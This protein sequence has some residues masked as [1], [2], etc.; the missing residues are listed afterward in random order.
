MAE[1]EAE[2]PPA[3]DSSVLKQCSEC[4]INIK[5]SDDDSKTDIHGFCREAKFNSKN[6]CF[7]NH[8]ELENG[9]IPQCTTCAFRMSTYKDRLA[10]ATKERSMQVAL[11]RAQ[12]ST[13]VTDTRLLF[14]ILRLHQKPEDAEMTAPFRSY[15]ATDEGIQTLASPEGQRQL[16]LLKGRLD[17][18][19]LSSI[20]ELANLTPLIESPEVREIDL[21][22]CKSLKV[23]PVESVIEL[24]SLKKLVLQ[25]CPELLFPPKEIAARDGAAVMQFL[26]HKIMDLKGTSLIGKEL[27]LFGAMA[28][29]RIVEMDVSDC[30]KLRSLPLDDILNISTLKQLRC[31]NCP[32]LDWP[33]QCV[34]PIGGEHTLECARSG[35]VDLR[36]RAAEL[37]AFPDPSTLNHERCTRIILTGCGRVKVIP[38]EPLLKIPNLSHLELVDTGVLWPPTKVIARGGEAVMEFLHSGEC[39]LEG[40][41]GLY[42]PDLTFL[43]EAFIRHLDLSRIVTCP[44]PPRDSL[45]PVATS[46]ISLS[47][48]GCTQFTSVAFLEPLTNAERVSLE[49]CTGLGPYLPDEVFHMLNSLQ[50]LVLTGCTGLKYPPLWVVELGPR[51]VGML[52]KLGRLDLSGTDYEEL[53]KELPDLDVPEIELKEIDLSNC[54]RLKRLPVPLLCGMTS[55]HSLFIGGCSSLTF[56]PQEVSERGGRACMRFLRERRLELRGSDFTT[57]DRKLLQCIEDSCVIEIDLSDSKKLETLPFEALCGMPH[58]EKLELKRCIALKWPPPQVIDRGGIAVMH[59]LRDGFLDLTACVTTELPDLALLCKH[60]PPGGGLGCRIREID[61]TNCS[62]LLELPYDQLLSIPTLEAVHCRGCPKL[63]WPPQRAI[64]LGGGRVM[65]HLRA[66]VWDLSDLGVDQ[67]VPPMDPELLMRAGVSTIDLSNS[68]KLWRL[69]MDQLSHITTLTSLEIRNCTKLNHPPKWLADRG[70]KVV[71]GLLSG[72]RLDIS[73]WAGLEQLP[74]GLVALMTR[75][76]GRELDVSGCSMLRQLPCEDLAGIPTLT[77]IDCSK[78]DALSWPPPAVRESGGKATCVFLKERKLDLSHQDMEEL[79]DFAQFEGASIREV[80]LTGCRRLKSLP[81]EMLIALP[82][83]F[84]VEVGGCVSLRHPPKS[85]QDRG[86]IIVFQFLKSRKLDWTDYRGSSIPHADIEALAE[87]ELIEID[88]SGSTQ[89]HTL[90]LDALQQLTTLESLKLGGCPKLHSPPQCV[91]VLDGARTLKFIRSKEYDVSGDPSVTT[92]DSHLAKELHTAGVRCVRAT[93]CQ[94]LTHVDGA[95]FGA[96]ASLTSLELG[97]CPALQWPPVVIT[98]RGGEATVEYVRKRRVDLRGSEFEAVPEELLRELA[99]AEV[100]EI[101]LCDCPNLT[102]LPAEALAGVASLTSLPC[103]NCPSMPWPPDL[104]RERGGGGP[105]SLS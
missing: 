45:L 22:D 50:E 57:I 75:V 101:D 48:K 94:N 67:E 99:E 93:G 27:P 36:P 35:W 23:V 43:S 18:T 42:F 64:Q 69:P 21:S 96:I 2:Q 73:N 39:L 34:A 16:P 25:G 76:K 82:E 66:G 59:F 13:D 20:V 1:A 90:P 65:E 56:P 104:V 98:S 40:Q 3:A 44:E 24:Q 85:V 47:A 11:M 78:C 10:N 83:C 51:T 38:V 84:S 74:E 17:F 33:P 6:C 19:G 28:R 105:S 80:V 8:I 58:L 62:K 88:L 4:F 5:G 9:G 81:V 15:L 54:A 52:M 87:A 14:E 30:V 41:P 97:E 91:C 12:R 72:K 37:D 68:Q 86:G 49:G 26:R 103:T 79:P 53:P 89:L 55:L 77:S 31:T 61:V 32:M 70:G 46:L 95:G 63:P 102:S 7:C 92:L 60:M 29:H 100:A 71:W